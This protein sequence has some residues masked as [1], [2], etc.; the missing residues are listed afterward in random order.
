MADHELRSACLCAVFTPDDEIVEV[1]EW[2]GINRA[3]HYLEHV[4]S[5][6]ERA[7]LRRTHESESLDRAHE[8]IAL[9]L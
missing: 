6:A 9:R 4:R 8:I 3:P 7:S 1:L 5:D 2:L